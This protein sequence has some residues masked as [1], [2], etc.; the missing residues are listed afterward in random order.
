M[1]RVPE[2]QTTKPIQKPITDTVMREALRD[3][4][5]MEKRSQGSQRLAQMAR[6][7]G[8]FKRRKWQI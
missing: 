7:R 6:L 2:N 5:G 1:V 8:F 3:F 4:A